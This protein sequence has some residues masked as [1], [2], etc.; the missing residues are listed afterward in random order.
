MTYPPI[1]D[2]KDGRNPRYA[3]IG[4]GLTGIATAIACLKHIENPA[5][6]W[7]FEP[8][9]CVSGGIAYGEAAPY[10]LLNIRAH[11]VSV[12]P[13]QPDDFLVWCLGRLG[14]G[15]E[16]SDL[17]TELSH[18]FLPRKLL[19]DYL[20]DR[21]NEARLENPHVNILYVNQSVDAIHPDAEGYHLDVADGD[22]LSVDKVMLAAGYHRPLSRHRKGL[23]GPYDRITK[24]MAAEAQSALLLGTGLSMVDAYLSLREAGYEGVVTAL[25]RRALMPQPHEPVCAPDYKLPNLKGLSINQV[26]RLVRTEARRLQ[27]SGYGEQAIFRSLRKQARILWQNIDIKQQKRFLRHIKPY[28]DSFRHRMPT[29]LR[30]RL[31]KD[32][33]K[34]NLRIERGRITGLDPEKG[35]VSFRRKGAQPDQK[36]EQLQSDIIIDCRGHRPNIAHSAVQTLINQELAFIDDHHLG[37][38]VNQRGAIIKADGTASKDLFALGPLG[39]GSLFEISGIPEIISQVDQT[40]RFLAAK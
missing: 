4:G 7:L 8:S 11:E 6:L 15:H 17:K 22:G 28:W 25:S 20:E 10:H 1:K 32:M 2:M 9:G 23:L 35:S 3:I 37:L 13:D 36:D 19:R 29:H 39:L 33:E 30:K 24:D 27:D 34:G 14:C 40:A 31:L 21:L 16:E 12:I 5:E 38:K 18:R 26:T